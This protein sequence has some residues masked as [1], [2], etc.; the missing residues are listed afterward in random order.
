MR[1]R[2]A[3]AGCWLLFVSALSNPLP[4]IAAPIQ[5]STHSVALVSV[6]GRVLDPTRSAIV[7]ARI[8]VRAN[9]VTG[10]TAITD[11]QGAFTVLLPRGQHTIAVTAAGFDAVSQTITVSESM[12]HVTEFVLPVSGVREAVTIS[13]PDGNRGLTTSTATRTVTAIRDV[14]QAITVV[15]QE[16]M[17]DQLMTS[18]SD[19]VRYVPGVTTHQG[20]NNRDQI[21]I[22][23]NSTSA[24][25]FVNGVRD[26]V[27]YFRDVYNIDRIEALK[28]PNAMIFGRGGAGGVVN[29]VLK[30]A[31][32]EPVRA[33]SLQA[34]MYSNRRLTADLD[35][36][37]SSTVAVR[38]N[39][40]FEQS[41]S[42]RDEVGLERYGLTP[43]VTIV[44][45]SQT[46][47]VFSYEHLHDSR[48]AD[49]GITS[50][51]GAPAAVDASLYYGNPDDSHVTLGV[52]LG[53]AMVEHRWRGATIRNRTVLAGYDRFYQNYVPGAASP[54]HTLVAL[55]AYNNASE[56]TNVFNQTDLIVAAT[57]GRIR[58]SL[59]FGAEIGRQWTDNFRNTG[60][61]NNA[62]TSIQVPFENPT[63][64]LPVT[65]RQSATD[66]DNHVRARIGSAY[67]QDQVE[68]SRRVQLVG[69]VRFDQFD[70]SHHNNRN[71]ETLNRLDNLVS[72]R[73]G[74]VFKP[75]TPLSIYGSYS[76]SYLPS[77]GDQFSSL[78]TITQQMKPEQ[79]TNYEVGAK[80]DLLSRLSLATAIYRLDRTNTRSTDPND[81][82][83]IVQTGSQR[84]N[85][86]E[87]GVDGRVTRSWRMAGGYAFQDAFVTS[88][89][90]AAKTGADVAQVPHHTFSLWNNYQLH[91]RLS[92]ALGVIYRS[93]MFAAIDNT[94]ALPSYTRIDAATFVPITKRARVQ[95]NVENLFDKRYFANADNN[96]NIS[97]GYPRTIRVALI[98]GF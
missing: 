75:V 2:F 31:V 47:V 23:G 54:N 69:G 82:T 34:G 51:A 30:E 33:V 37:V 66:A 71:G 50:L 80:W 41:D 11:A 96:T 92:A 39:G 60:F 9:G 21:I 73:A 49:R 70:L 7:G 38:F 58:H 12:T 3:S 35:Q 14:P 29:R 48:T 86:Y 36:P 63:I 78:T 42:F 84:T 98:T 16:L 90:T 40:M 55:S 32:F 88:A 97:P 18:I 25:F 76:V 53:S 4:L 5:A 64:S 59:L 68:V 62:A 65:Y 52:N 15:G 74:V 79:F 89:T 45:T 1:R 81:P 95:V 8:I 20:E 67:A 27:Q 43:T 26:D 93:D 56:R 24:D 44:P 72:P 22:R 6:Q 94:V 17:K 46:R 19:V 57:T 10:A 77:A 13:A 91:P 28:G 85:G 87:V 61:F 83:R